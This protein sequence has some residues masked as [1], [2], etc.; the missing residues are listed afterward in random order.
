MLTTLAVTLCATSL[1]ADQ[2]SPHGTYR[3]IDRSHSV[4]DDYVGRF[5]A[6]IQLG[7]PSGL[8]AK[9]WLNDKL[10]IDGAAGWSL[11]EHSDFY[12]Q[13]DLLI[14]NF[15][16]LPVPSGKFPVYIG[17]GAFIRFRDEHHENQAGVRLPI[18]VDYLFD[19]AP[20]DVFVEFAPGVQLT[21]S[22]R[23]DFAGGIGIRYW[24]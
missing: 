10:A 6:G 16:L 9:Y 5:G 8:S 12:V 11:Y 3:P 17:G 7:E 22:T 24:F 1:L 14:H 2:P 18:G 21:P 13:S 20:V 15:D 19:N 4:A 23:A